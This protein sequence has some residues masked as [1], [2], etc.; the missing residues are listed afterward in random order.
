MLTL[1]GS[2]DSP[3]DSPATADGDRYLRLPDLARYASLS[4]R[5][6][7]KLIA[8]RDH[9]LPAYRL[10]KAVRVRK[11]DF[12]RWLAERQDRGRI[13]GADLSDADR[14]IARALRGYP[15]ETR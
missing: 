5:Y 11:S 15:T 10:G 7:Q 14:R 2:S 13:A 8:D 12:D 1:H 4:V 3:A 9:P 6:L